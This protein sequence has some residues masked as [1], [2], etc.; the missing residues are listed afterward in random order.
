M[1]WPLGRLFAETAAAAFHPA[2]FQAACAADA[3]LNRRAQA[4]L[5]RLF[6]ETAATAFQ[7]AAF[8]GVSGAGTTAVSPA[9]VA[10]KVLLALAAE[11]SRE[12]KDREGRASF[13]VACVVAFTT[14]SRAPV[15]AA[16]PAIPYFPSFLDTDF[17]VAMHYVV[18][19]YDV[20]SPE[21]YAELPAGDRAWSD[22]VGLV[23]HNGRWPAHIFVRFRCAAEIAAAPH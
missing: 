5:G 9:R 10:R 23:S 13:M 19:P 17:K 8:Q 3:G 20:R 2:A 12:V 22:L 11:A 1:D 15:A 7:P 6:A 21:G 4:A 18:W 16:G 14:A